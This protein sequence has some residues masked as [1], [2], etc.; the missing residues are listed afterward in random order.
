MHSGAHILP[1]GETEFR[2]WAPRARQIALR[3]NG[4]THA[5]QPSDHGHYSLRLPANLTGADYF[6]LLDGE[7]ERPD[8]ASRFQP[9]GVHGP[10]RVVDP[11]AFAW[12]D[13]AWSGLPLRDYVAYEMHTG[14]FTPEGTF[15]AAIARL[16]YLRELG[17]TALE[18]M[19]VA[20]FPGARN[21]G[22]DGVSL[23]APHRDYGGPGG[24]KRLVDACHRAGL[25]VI[26]DVVYNHLGPEGNYLNE[27]GPYFTSRYQT[28]WGPALNFDGEDS[29]P[30]RRFFLDNALYWL[31][32][33]HF[34]A[35]RLDAVHGIFDFSA[36]HL[37]AEMV[38]EVDAEAARQG[39]P[40]FLIAESDLNDARI[41]EDRA[42]GG[43]AVHAQ[44]MDDFHHSVNTALLGRGH[45]YLEDFGALG[46]LAK[47]LSEGFVYDGRYSQ[48]RRR[49]FGNSSA[50]L[51]GDRFM[52]CTQNHDQV[53]NAGRGRRLGETAGL[54]R[55]KLAACLLVAAP[56]LPMLFQGQEYGE[57]APFHY[58]VSHGDAA[59]VEAVREGRRRE[60]AAFVS[61]EEFADPQSEA[62]FLASK[63]D[64]TKLD[65]EP[66]AALLRLYQCLFAIR[67]QRESLSNCRKDLTRVEYDEQARWLVMQRASE[68]G[69]RTMLVAN[70][71]A[72]TVE[73]PFDPAG[74]RWTLLLWTG[75]PR[76]AGTGAAAPAQPPFTLGP[77]AAALFAADEPAS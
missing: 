34:D 35:L 45:G 6:F 52:V 10:S 41:V 26:L 13:Q 61:A 22:Y 66:H 28:P 53:A 33:F 5:L 49:R 16:P 36:R 62:T 59:L 57:T 44:W 58:F 4:E 11:A 68:S 56:C 72:Q 15:D 54:E 2:V 76:F 69:E 37:L 8:P 48:H 14:T 77:W 18:I 7:R 75:D 25:A 55:E 67:R 21:W 73:V 60:F 46:D 39:R 12:S 64:W 19:P 65:R 17:V 1:S 20:E 9:F 30:V 3:I 31:T 32:E 51:P 63:L 27:F 47:A 50:H 74:R 70:F 23:F 40:L 24:L 29:D 43:H 38:D 42:R 71:S